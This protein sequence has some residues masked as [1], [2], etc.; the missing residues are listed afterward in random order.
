MLYHCTEHDCDKAFTYKE[1]RDLHIKEVHKK[2]TEQVKEEHTKKTSDDLYE[3]SCSHLGLG[4]LLHNADDAIKEGDGGRLVRVWDFLIYLFK[5]NGNT[6]YALASLCLKAA[7]LALLSPQRAHQLTWNRFI[8][9]MV[10]KGNAYPE[11]L[12]LSISTKFKRCLLNL[13]VFKIYRM[14]MSEKFPSQLGVW[15]QYSSL[16]WKM[17]IY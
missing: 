11:T 14:K 9:H 3:W 15:K 2:L 16:N 4:L 6:K 12:D 13:K 8:I 1:S 10:C 7:R 5:I 17:L